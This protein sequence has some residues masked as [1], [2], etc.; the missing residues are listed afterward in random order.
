MQLSGAHGWGRSTGALLV[1]V[2]AV[3]SGEPG[4]TL[5]RDDHGSFRGRDRRHPLVPGNAGTV[6]SAE[7]RGWRAVSKPSDPRRG[8]STRA[9]SAG[10]LARELEGDAR[11]EEQRPMTG[12]VG[13][14]E[15]VENSLGER[16]DDVERQALARPQRDAGVVGNP[17]EVRASRRGGDREVLAADVEGRAAVDREGRRLRVQEGLTRPRFFASQ[18]WATTTSD[19]AGTVHCPPK[20][21]AHGNAGTTAVCARAA[22]GRASNA[23]RRTS[24]PAVRSPRPPPALLDVIST[25]SGDSPPSVSA[26]D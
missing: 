16:D 26:A 5:A 4:R 1:P 8:A 20:M 11:P 15:P 9:V 14:R 6:A 24:T 25:S 18:R 22:A 3:V 12:F 17:R 19:P 7:G 23:V 13:Q 10:D 21:T 2:E